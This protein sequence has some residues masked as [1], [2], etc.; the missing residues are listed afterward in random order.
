M[1]ISA[2]SM[3]WERL[4]LARPGIHGW[5]PVHR[6]TDSAVGLNVMCEGAN[7]FMFMSISGSL[8][9]WISAG[10]AAWHSLVGFRKAESIQLS[11]QPRLVG[12]PP[13]QCPPCS[14]KGISSPTPHLV[15]QLSKQVL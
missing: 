5:A 11:H 6:R 4:S 3:L 7:K 1:G 15:Q 14:M 8:L 13:L 10:P 12:Q 9:V 2:L